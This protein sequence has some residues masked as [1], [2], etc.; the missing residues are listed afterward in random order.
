[1]SVSPCGIDCDQCQ[2]RENCDDSCQV[3]G[4]KPFYIKDFGVEV[5]PIYD[6]SINK[7]GYKTCAECSDLP[8]QL[9]YDWKDPSMSDEV[10]N[11]AISKN[12]AFLK[13]QK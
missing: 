2:L 1:M 3:N 9:F 7:N 13:G 12:V 5:C 8:C 4:G 6:C 11:E 10:H